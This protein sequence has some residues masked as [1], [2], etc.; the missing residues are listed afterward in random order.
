MEEDMAGE[1]EEYSP[2][3][4]RR[5]EQIAGDIQ[6]IADNVGDA[7]LADQLKTYAEEIRSICGESDQAQ[8]DE[9]M[10]GEPAEAMPKAKSA[11][12]KM[13]EAHLRKAVKF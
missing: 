11:T 10:E 8:A 12:D 4:N 13:A 3:S 1:A 6:A 2:D 7:S 5:L 9:D